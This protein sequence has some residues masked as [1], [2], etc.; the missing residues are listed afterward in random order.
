MAIRWRPK[1]S[2][3]ADYSKLFFYMV[4]KIISKFANS[5]KHNNFT[6]QTKKLKCLTSMFLEVVMFTDRS[7]LNIS[8]VTCNK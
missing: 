4:A 6:F 5:Q 7:D 1:E 8:R 2:M 3:T